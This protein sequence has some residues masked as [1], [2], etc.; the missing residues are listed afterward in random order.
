MIAT[1]ILCVII[2]IIWCVVITPFMTIVFMPFAMAGGAPGL[3][4]KEK[5]FLSFTPLLIA[6]LAYIGVPVLIFCLLL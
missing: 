1:I 6:G 5:L 2:S 3:S 4:D